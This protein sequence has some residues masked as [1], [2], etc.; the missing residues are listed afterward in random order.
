MWQKIS[1]FHHAEEITQDTFLQ[2]YKKLR[3]LKDPRQFSG[4]L[5]VIANRL[6][7]DWT[8]KQSP[9]MQSLWETPAKEIEKS[10]YTRYV[11]EKQ[12]IEAATYRY[13]IVYKLL[14]RLPENERRVVKLYYLDEMTAKEIG[15]FLGVSANTIS[16]RLQRARKRLQTDEEL[17]V[18]EIFGGVQMP[19]NMMKN[20]KQQIAAFREHTKSDPLSGEDI[21]TEACNQVEGA[22]KDEITSELVHLA[23]EIYEYMGKLGYAKRVSLHRGYLGVAP[24]NAERFWSHSLLM[25]S[26]NMLGRNREVV[27]EQS[28]LYRWTCKHL[29]D[30]YVLEILGYYLSETGCWKAE[31]RIDEWFQ[32]YDEASERLGNPEVDR[33]K[34]CGFLQTGAEV[35]MHNDRLDETLLAIEKLERSNDD[36]SWG[37]Y[38]QYWLGAITTRLRVHSKREDWTR[39][40]QVFTEASAFIEGEVE[41]RDAGHPVNRMDLAWIAH[42]VGACLMWSKKHHK[43][44]HLLQVAIDSNNDPGTHFFLAA[45]IWTSEKDR[46]KT[47]HHLKIAQ[48]IE[49]NPWNR[50]PFLRS[51]LETPEFSDVKDDKEFLKVLGQKSTDNG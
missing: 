19:E 40:D 43:A 34:R 42:D 33:E 25:G 14:D 15:K 7:I 41:K 38:R 17:Q 9:A 13:E 10:F 24:D 5:Y 48:D 28:R 26:L 39:F 12:E 22:L 31:G 8:R 27:E 23:D 4:W 6:C 21:L 29:S 18:Q 11:A 47:L 51:F 3:T 30:D 35:L 20:I 36:P 1:D 44:K 2:A 37:Y 32:L 16:S 49:S 46:E 50:D 45:N